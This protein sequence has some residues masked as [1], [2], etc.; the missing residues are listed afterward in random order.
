MRT[1]GTASGRCCST[2]EHSRAFLYQPCLARACC[3]HGS[4]LE[5]VLFNLLGDFKHS[6]GYTSTASSTPLHAQQAPDGQP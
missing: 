1:E 5:S 4:K 6:V 2:A 3:P